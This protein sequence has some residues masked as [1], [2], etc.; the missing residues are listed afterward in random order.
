MIA[1]RGNYRIESLIGKSIFQLNNHV[2]SRYDV[3]YLINAKSC[4][5]D[6]R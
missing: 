3:N 2:Y 6:T 5:F 4:G 1:N